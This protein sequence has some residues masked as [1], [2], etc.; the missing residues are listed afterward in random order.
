MLGASGVPAAC[1]RLGLPKILGQSPPRL[2]LVG[3]SMGETAVGYSSKSE[4]GL[5]N[6]AIVEGVATAK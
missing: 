2:K 3:L 5:A 4:I 6:R 1:R